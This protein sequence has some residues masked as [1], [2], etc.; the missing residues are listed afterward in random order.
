[1]LVVSGMNIVES[2]KVHGGTYDHYT[3]D[4][5]N[6]LIDVSKVLGHSYVKAILDADKAAFGSPNPAAD[7]LKIDHLPQ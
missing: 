6:L 3:A 7:H 2:G 4:N 5:A 1:M